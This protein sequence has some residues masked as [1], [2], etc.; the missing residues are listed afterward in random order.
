[1]DGQVYVDLNGATADGSQPLSNSQ[2]LSRIL[3]A[4]GLPE[5]DVLYDL[6]DSVSLLR[7]FCVDK[8]I[9]FYL[10]NAWSSSQIQDLFPSGEKSAVIVTSRRRLGDLDGAEHIL[11]ASLDAESSLSL[12]QKLTGRFG[13]NDRKQLAVIGELCGNLPLALRIAAA[14][15]TAQPHLPL[16]DMIEALQD[17]GRRLDEIKYG[18]R[19]IRATFE[20]TYRYI[21]AFRKRRFILAS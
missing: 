9:L 15:L 17:E 8:A 13:G 1:V 6:P 3:H 4:F 19:A 10:D 14:R 16:E 18:D 21:S 2:A 11:L 7:T 12:L 20:A 5:S